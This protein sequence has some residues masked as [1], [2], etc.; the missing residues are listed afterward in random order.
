MACEN[1][2]Q[3]MSA[4]VCFRRLF[5]ISF[6]DVPG[7]HGSSLDRKERSRL[8]S[9]AL[10]EVSV[11][12]RLCSRSRMLVPKD[13]PITVTPPSTRPLTLTLAPL[14]GGAPLEIT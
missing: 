7:P 6:S 2:L 8:V 14:L 10:L 12:R 1:R 11:Q 4:S 13:F 9:L 5:R 3:L